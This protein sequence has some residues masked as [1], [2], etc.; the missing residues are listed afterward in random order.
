MSE[1][2]EGETGG[3]SIFFG[4]VRNVEIKIENEESLPNLTYVI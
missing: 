3:K 4:E 2:R 1:K